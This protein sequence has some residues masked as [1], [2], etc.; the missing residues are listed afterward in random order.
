[1]ATKNFGG[2]SSL[3]VNCLKIGSGVGR[4]RGDVLRLTLSLLDARHTR[5]WIGAPG[6]LHHLESAAFSVPID[7]H[8]CSLSKISHG[9]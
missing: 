9:T 1:M 8:D 7:G 4:G 2:Q 6:A 5:V 3:G